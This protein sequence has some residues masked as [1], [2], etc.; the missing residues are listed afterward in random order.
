MD[1]TKE[2]SQANEKKWT[3][4][5]IQAIEDKGANFLVSAA[6]GSGKT[7]VLIERIVRKILN[8]NVNVDDLL[9]VTFTNAAASEMKE[10]LL[11]ALYKKLDEDPDNE[12]LQKQISLINRAHISTIHSFCLDVIRNNFFE[13]NLS[14]NFRIADDSEN[15]IIKQE[16]MEKVFEDKYEAKDKT[17]LSLLE[18]YTNYKDD[19]PL[20]DL[21]DEIYSF[22]SSVPFPHKWL[23][24]AINKFELKNVEEFSETPWGESILKYSK[25]KFETE[26]INANQIRDRIKDYTNLAPWISTVDE[27]IKMIESFNISTWDEAY[28]TANAINK[29]FQT[30]SSSKRGLNDE[31]IE[32]KNRAKEDRDII[33]K[34]IKNITEKYFKFDSRQAIDDI[35]EMYPTLIALRNL[36]YDFEKEY[37]RR[38][39]EKNII[40]FNDIEHIALNL[41]IDENGEKTEIAKKYSFNEILVDEYQDSNLIQESILSSVSNGHNIFMVGDVKQSIYRFREARP[42]LFQEKYEKYD[43]AIQGETNLN[44]PSKVQLYKNFRSRKQ[45][46]DFTNTIFQFIMSKDLGEMDYTEEEYLNYGANYEEPSF[47][48]STEMYVI[49][50]NKKE[51]TQDIWKD[52]ENDLNIENED[53]EENEIE[54]EVVEW[55]TL[56]ADLLC[57]KIK[58]LHDQGVQYRDMCILMRSPSTMA[59]IFEK[60][61]IES[62]IPVFTDVGSDYLHT[63]E[64]DTILSLLNVI[65][66]PL[67]DIQLITAMRSPIGGFNDNDLVD[68]RLFDREN[69]FYYAL[70]KAYVELNPADINHKDLDLI[71]V[72]LFEK[73]RDFLNLIDD[74]R[75][76]EK[77]MPLDELIWYIYVKTGYYHYVRMMPNGKIRQA[78]LR[79][80]FEKAKEYESISFKGL[81]NFI[82]FIERVAS[83]PKNTIGAAK[84]IGENEDVVRIMSIH[85][86]KGLEFPVVF[87]C[88]VG[89]QFNLTDLSNKVILNQ[90]LGLGV[91]F[92]NEYTRYPTLAKEAINIKA[93]N[94][95]V[96]EE[97]R[98]LYVALTRAKEKLLIIG[99]DKKAEEKYNKKGEEI[100]KF[101]GFNKHEKLSSKI[102]SKYARYIDWIELVNQAT[103]KLNLK[104][105]FVS[106]ED[107]ERPASDEDINKIDLRKL[108]VNLDKAKYQQIDEL[109][110]WE[111]KDKVRIDLQSKTSVTAL[112][113]SNLKFEDSE[114][115]L[116]DSLNDEQES[117]NE[118]TFQTF[119]E[120][121]IDKEEELTSAHKGT[122]IHK[123]LEKI[124]DEDIERLIEKLKLKEFEKEYLIKDKK[125]IEN[126]IESDLFKALKEAKEIH[127]ETPF[128]MN[129]D[130]EGTGEKILIQG[131]IDLYYIDKDGDLILVDYKTDHNVD[132]KVLK[133]R[134]SNQLNMYKIAIEKSTHRKVAQKVI[135][136]TYLNKLVEI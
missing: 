21:I 36:L 64:I 44:N 33:K 56:E 66:N 7:T 52:E 95:M 135:Y 71:E 3:D 9:V 98:L 40:D 38:K 88:G 15:E 84:I 19:T 18:K 85:K 75:K 16:A 54:E 49:E 76:K 73:I 61:M 31:E 59:P 60:E 4:E 74:L 32:I 51:P 81:F 11:K 91:D 29:S 78:N 130:Y 65:D 77:V 39:M 94:E 14:A 37:N 129:I 2:Q 123:A 136:S 57:T 114:V 58:E 8:D 97:M 127:K 92:I 90:D 48:V 69:N 70:Q 82:T 132:E 131:V 112:K 119:D 133:E 117:F 22:T 17:F 113:N 89:K 6:A 26:A 125:I 80:L 50:K 93:R 96:S 101:F 107:I 103:D 53:E 104:I 105:N 63:I 121:K 128:Y 106:R 46:L 126:Y 102:V 110:K 120:L 86:S 24:E 43:L 20:K 116:L 67:Q 41:L 62:N 23:E 1:K 27:D 55:S 72:R 83:K 87:L 79:K 68:I 25:E 108:E 28:K 118:N 99:S 30:W 12:N 134:Y 111:Y 34:K 124:E 45:I 122:L 100:K 47:D 115:V 42:E 10:R 13:T 35:R 109:L 5:Q